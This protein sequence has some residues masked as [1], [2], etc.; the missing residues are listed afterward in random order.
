M[1]QPAFACRLCHGPSNRVTL[2]PLRWYGL[3]AIHCGRFSLAVSLQSA[4]AP[5]NPFSFRSIADILRAVAQCHAKGVI[6]RDVK[7]ENFL[8]LSKRENSPLKM[9]DFGLA[10]YCKQGQVITERSVITVKIA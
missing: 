10:E 8:F 6:L 7:P 2:L 4:A 1:C 9:V 3:Y 5:G